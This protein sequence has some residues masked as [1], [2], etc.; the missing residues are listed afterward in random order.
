MPAAA[1]VRALAAAA[2]AHAAIA[3]D[4]LRL[5]SHDHR[6]SRWLAQA[7]EGHN[8]DETPKGAPKGLPTA[9]LFRATPKGVSFYAFVF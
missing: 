9:F 3:P 1:A 7:L 8:T 6:L 2:A 4:A 5:I